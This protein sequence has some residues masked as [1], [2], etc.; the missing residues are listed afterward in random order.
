MLR[1]ILFG[2]KCLAK[3]IQDIISEVWV[4][5]NRTVERAWP[6]HGKIVPPSLNNLALD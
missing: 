4:K 1:Q 3:I 5:P 6:T 2:S